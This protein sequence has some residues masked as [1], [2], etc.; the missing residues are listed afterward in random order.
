MNVSR[1]AE[2]NPLSER[3]YRHKLLP[4]DILAHPVTQK[5]PR[6]MAIS[7]EALYGARGTLD[8]FPWVAA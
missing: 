8:D 4:G 1:V 7:R 6:S 5:S 2:R 3:C